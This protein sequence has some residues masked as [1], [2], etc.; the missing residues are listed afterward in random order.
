MPN[1]ILKIKEWLYSKVGVFNAQRGACPDKD[2]YK[3]TIGRDAEA[4]GEAASKTSSRGEDSLASIRRAGRILQNA[5]AFARVRLQE[6]NG[7]KPTYSS[8]PADPTING[9][10]LPLSLAGVD[11]RSRCLFFSLSRSSPPSHRCS[12][13]RGSEERWVAMVEARR[14][15][16]AH[17][18][19]IRHWPFF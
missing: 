5:A 19:R 6:M 15:S 18:Y 1:R 17:A 13:S 2:N 7:R 12:A 9:M 4:S 11:S 14:L 10:S 16:G 3:E 8:W